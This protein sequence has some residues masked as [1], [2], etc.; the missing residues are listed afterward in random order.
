VTGTGDPIALCD[1]CAD[2]LPKWA[3]ELFGF[4]TAP[5]VTGTECEAC[6]TQYDYT[7]W[8][9]RRNGAWDWYNPDDQIELVDENGDL[10]P[11]DYFDDLDFDWRSLLELFAI[12]D[13]VVDYLGRA[14]SLA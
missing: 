7:V 2:E 1:R 13:V 5:D 4:T 10:L 12:G 8:L 6:R 11:D 3:D 9:K 14:V